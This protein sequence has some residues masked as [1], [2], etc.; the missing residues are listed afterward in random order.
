MQIFEFTLG[1]VEISILALVAIVI[2]ATIFVFRIQLLG[3]AL[4][5]FDSHLRKIKNRWGEENWPES[6]DDDSLFSLQDDRKPVVIKGES[7]VEEESGELPLY[8][9]YAVENEDGTLAVGI[10]DDTLRK[11]YEEGYAKKR[12]AFLLY[13]D[14]FIKQRTPFFKII[15]DTIVRGFP[16]TDRDPLLEELYDLWK[17][18]FRDVRVAVCFV[19]YFASLNTENWKFVLYEALAYGELA[20]EEWV[21]LNFLYNDVTKNEVLFANFLSAYRNLTAIET[22]DISIE[23]N[24]SRKHW[25]RAEFRYWQKRVNK[26]LT[27]G[28]TEEYF[29][30]FF[31]ESFRTNTTF[32]LKYYLIKNY[33]E[34]YYEEYREILLRQVFYYGKYDRLKRLSFL[35]PELKLLLKPGEE[36]AEGV[37]WESLKLLLQEYPFAGLHYFYANYLAKNENAK[38][39][40]LEEGVLLHLLE[41]LILKPKDEKYVPQHI[42][43]ILFIYFIMKEDWQNLDYTYKFL[44]P[45][46]RHALGDV[47]YARALFKRG[48]FEKA[49]N[50][51][52]TIWKRKETNLLLM[53][54][55]AIYAYHA[56]RIQ[57]A[58]D[59]FK[60]MRLLYPNNS[61]VLH[62]ESVF[63]QFKAKIVDKFGELEPDSEDA[64][65]SQKIA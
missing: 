52:L 44:S 25:S 8:T 62:N 6:V 28:F 38:T 15:D 40:E 64:P 21:I 29:I 42:R 30:E 16:N 51:I 39:F 46:F 45:H 58:E 2:L 55:A 1:A 23:C 43:Y 35:A 19:H 27:N 59:I 47:Y 13:K 63:L 7:D 10:Q 9:E 20:E 60:K 5:S 49:W 11:I 26:S 34:K 37:T 65:D 14:E 41:N 48:Y 12:D 33:E 24:E 22:L 56:G 32:L 4:G 18:G 54:E 50:A 61:K 17:Y 31:S 57:E 3:G 36:L 53:N